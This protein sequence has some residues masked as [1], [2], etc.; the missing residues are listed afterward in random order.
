MVESGARTGTRWWDVYGDR[1]GWHGCHA[2][3]G[4]LTD[5]V[6]RHLM[7]PHPDLGRDGPVC[8]FVQHSAARHT[9]WAAMVPGGDE[10]T[11]ER[12][13]AVVDDAIEAYGKL[14]AGGDRPPHST[15]LVTVFPELT[16]CARI[17]A[18]HGE[19][20]TE[21]V[22]RGWMLGQFY[23]GCTV[24]GL[25]N[26]D[27]HPLDAPLPML[28]LRPMMS[29]DYPF[30]VG[31]SEWLYAYFTHLAPNLPRRLRWEIAERM[32]VAGPAAGEITALRAHAP[33]EHAR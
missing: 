32:R 18:V 6:A 21:V 19:R 10:V 23:P 8:P 14:V 20:K 33:G 3:A 22:R 24:P 4:T 28:V 25:W 17:D 7:A 5:W 27:F 15:A 2:A 29:T 12:M 16:D 31:R 30:L 13:H 1:D 11:V 26:R 9:L